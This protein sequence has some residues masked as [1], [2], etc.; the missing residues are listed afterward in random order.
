MKYYNLLNINIIIGVD[1]I[2]CDNLEIT[3]FINNK[4]PSSNEI[5]EISRNMWVSNPGY[6]YNDESNS[7]SITKNDYQWDEDEVR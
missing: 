4:N 1:D 2:K 6:I 5:I 3:K 7:K